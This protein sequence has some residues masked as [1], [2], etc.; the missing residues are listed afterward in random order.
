MRRTADV[1]APLCCTVLLF[2]F[3]WLLT[4]DAERDA[5]ALG[6]LGA[7]WFPPTLA[8]SGATHP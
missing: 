6:A 7:V 4:T 2:D 8:I 3:L 5:G 1:C